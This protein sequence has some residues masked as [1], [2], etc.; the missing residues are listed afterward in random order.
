MIA[1][2]NKAPNQT[3]PA[4]FVKAFLLAQIPSYALAILAGLLWPNDTP[5]I[6]LAGYPDLSPWIQL[7][8]SGGII[9]FLETALLLYPTA[10]A[11][12]AI[13]KR[14]I[15]SFIGAAPIVLLHGLVAWQKPFVIAWSFYVQS[16]VYI[17]LR[18]AGF[19]IRTAYMFVFLMHALTNSILVSVLFFK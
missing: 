1:L 12:Q 2:L 15:S 16:F 13:G 10:L 11:H 18:A 3:L 7:A 5:P 4:Y 17:E 19:S 8:F 14:E 9:P 6:H